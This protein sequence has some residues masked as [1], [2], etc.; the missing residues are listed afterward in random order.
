MIESSKPMQHHATNP[1]RV[2]VQ[3][4]RWPQ[5]VITALGLVILTVTPLAALSLQQATASNPAKLSDGEIAAQVK[6]FVEQLVAADEF[7][8]AVLVAKDGKPIFR[9]AYGLA[10]KA[11]NVPNRIDT[12]FNLG[13]MNKMFTAVAVAQL[14]AAGKLAYDDPIGKHLSDYPNKEV[15]HRRPSAGAAGQST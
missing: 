5:L 10:S 14:A 13:S 3:G 7:S 15:R 1:I 6:E 11:Y 8:G 4:Y 9:S 2:R 12:K